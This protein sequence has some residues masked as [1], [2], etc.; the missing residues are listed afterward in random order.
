V[1][2][3]LESTRGTVAGSPS[4]PRPGFSDIAMKEGKRGEDRNVMKYREE[5]NGTA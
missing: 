2:D 5:G 3:W 4:L 1:G